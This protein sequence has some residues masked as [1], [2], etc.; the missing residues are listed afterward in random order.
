[1][2][3]LSGP[4][5]DPS[6]ARREDPS[7]DD[8]LAVARRAMVSRQIASR[9][10]RDPRVLAAMERV[11]RHAF[12]PASECEAAYEDRPLPIGAGQT[13]SQ[14]YIVALMSEALCLGGTERV[15]EIGTGS[16]YQT[17]VLAAL[18]GQVYSLEIVPELASRAALALRSLGAA[19]VELR[20][21]DGTTGW[22]EAAPFA[23]I[24]VTA[25]PLQ[26]PPVLLE[27]LASGGRLVLPVGPED[28]QQLV[29]I[30]R[31]ASGY[32]RRTLAPVRFVPMTGAARNPEKTC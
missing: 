16:G 21:G 14:P 29:C 27:Q 32:H 22:P 7:S 30:Q 3:A 10:I 28:D 9:G 4:T 2:T 25:A 6:P 11:P 8:P 31:S 26:V 12:V 5:A 13:I 15:L 24:L 23:G 1:M 18:A 20:V 17:A 19:N